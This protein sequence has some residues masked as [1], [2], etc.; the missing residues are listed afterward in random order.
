MAL[1]TGDTTMPFASYDNLLINSYVRLM[2]AAFAHSCSETLIIT[3]DSV[4][5]N[6]Y[7]YCIEGRPAGPVR[8]TESTIWVQKIRQKFRIILR[9]N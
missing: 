4:W 1:E 2:A 7:A 6:L 8:I 5:T 9:D 3:A